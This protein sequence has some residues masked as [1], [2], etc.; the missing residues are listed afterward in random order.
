MRSDYC[1]QIDTSFIDKEVTL[2]GSLGLSLKSVSYQPVPL[3][4]KLPRE[5]N[6]RNPG[7]S[8]DGQAGGAGSFTF[9]NTS[10]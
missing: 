2:C 10:N 9:C 8:Q 3:S 5:I 4:L 1:G 6:F 7:C